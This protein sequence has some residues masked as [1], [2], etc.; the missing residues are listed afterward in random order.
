MSDV[1]KKRRKDWLEELKKNWC[2]REFVVGIWALS[3]EHNRLTHS[4]QLFIS[5]KLRQTLR[6]C[7]GRILGIY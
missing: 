7:S 3:C 4:E 1:I 6:G 5:T 2:Y